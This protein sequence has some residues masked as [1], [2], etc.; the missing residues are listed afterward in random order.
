MF[1]WI[2]RWDDMFDFCHLEMTND[3]PIK[4]KKKKNANCPSKVIKAGE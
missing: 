3:K 1:G 2:R 4:K